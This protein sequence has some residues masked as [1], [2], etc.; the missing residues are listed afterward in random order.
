MDSSVVE[1]DASL[2]RLTWKKDKPYKF[3]N[4]I[5]SVTYL[6]FRAHSYFVFRFFNAFL[7]AGDGDQIAVIGDTGHA[8]L[9]CCIFLQFSK[10]QALLPKNWTA[11]LFRNGDLLT[12]LEE[13]TLNISKNCWKINNMYVKNLYCISIYHLFIIWVARHNQMSFAAILT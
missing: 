12:R 9:C 2:Y 13:H 11:M 10:F 5:K 6:F 8:Y 7:S 1:M 3:Y 4:L